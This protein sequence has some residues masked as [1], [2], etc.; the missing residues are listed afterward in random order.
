MS[1][2]TS[3]KAKFDLRLTQNQAFTAGQKPDTWGLLEVCLPL[4]CTLK[5][6]F[7]YLCLCRYYL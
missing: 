4:L 6:L 2:R 3:L 1:F 5:Y 7:Y